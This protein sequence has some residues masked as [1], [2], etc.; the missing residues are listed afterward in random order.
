MAK[1]LARKTHQSSTTATTTTTK[2][3]DNIMSSTDPIL[4]KA[5][6]N[7]RSVANQSTTEWNVASST[8]GTFQGQHWPSH[9]PKPP[10]RKNLLSNNNNN[11]TTPG[12]GNVAATATT[13]ATNNAPTVIVFN[14]NTPEGS[15]MVRVLSE[16]K[17]NVVA[18]VRVFT[19]KTTKHLIKLPNVTVKV[20]DLNNYDACI[21]AAQNCCSAFL[22]TKYWERFESPIEEAMAKNVLSAAA[23]TGTIKRFVLA[24]FEDTLTLR[25]TNRKSQLIPTI[26]GR[27]Y[28]SFDG[29]T[30]FNEMGKQLHISV[31][32]MFTSYLDESKNI[33]Q[34]HDQGSS[35]TTTATKKSIILIR[36]AENNKIICQSHMEQVPILSSTSSA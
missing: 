26:D 10:S 25:N 24:T 4:E 12:S 34:N 19:S 13:T 14:A 31:T 2:I 20:A 30:S 8:N 6:N 3:K 35:I 11:D 16:K 33:H 15:S 22:I 27:I 5:R 1:V 32:H 18:V 21:L 29:M 36:S 7:H 9:L 23:Q 28:P 17:M